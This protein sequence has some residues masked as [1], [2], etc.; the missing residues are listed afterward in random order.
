MKV[1]LIAALMV[2]ARPALAGIPWPEQ[3]DRIRLAE[4]FRLAD[5]VQDSVWEGWS[6]VP[7]VILLVTEGH[8]YLLRHPYPPEDFV[9]LGWDQVTGEEIF[10]RPNSGAFALD[11]LATFPAIRGVNTVVVGRPANTGKDSTRWVVTL[12][13]E[14]FHQLQ[15]TRP[16]YY[17]MV[18][19]LD[20]ADGDT[21]GMWQLNYPFPYASERAGDVLDA[22][23]DALLRDLD[24]SPGSM[25]EERRAA[26]LALEHELDGADYRYLSFQ[27]W[28]EGVARY[29]EHAVAQ[30]AAAHHQPLPAFTAL[31]DYVPYAAA[32]RQLEAQ[33]RSELRSLE[34][35][36]WK[37]VVF[38]PLGAAEALLLD[39]A[40][41]GWKA[42][43][44]TEPFYLERYLD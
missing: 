44:F 24:A 35:A 6:K 32:L 13:H 3:A 39:A 2:C 19:A 25:G 20:L 5:S 8:E 38:Y 43:Y 27:L 9:S 11:F 10:A 7:F 18:A 21:S 36:G 30:A 22:Y 12:L 28:Q 40:R 16:G 31:D 15:Y 33:L 42:R 23:R 17:D 1:L 29:T 37:R 14:H 34:L 4:A 41:P 26:R